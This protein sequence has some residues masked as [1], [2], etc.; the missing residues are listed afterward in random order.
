MD[1]YL[2][3]RSQIGILPDA[4]RL[5]RKTPVTADVMLL[6]VASGKWNPALVESPGERLTQAVNFELLVSYLRGAMDDSLYVHLRPIALARWLRALI[7]VENIGSVGY[8]S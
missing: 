7:A 3:R 4:I 8:I 2:L 1:K 5:R 6:H